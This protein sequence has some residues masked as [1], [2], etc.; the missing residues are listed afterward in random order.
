MVAE[1]D[2]PTYKGWAVTCAPPAVNQSEPPSACAPVATAP[3]TAVPP[4]V[5]SN[6]VQEGGFSSVDLSNPL[7]KQAAPRQPVVATISIADPGKIAFDEAATNVSSV[8]STITFSFKVT[9]PALVRYQLLQ[10]SRRPSNAARGF[11]SV[12]ALAGAAV[13]TGA[14][15]WWLP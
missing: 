5:E 4:A 12:G 2:L 11:G 3:C 8:G 15:G 7:P 10:V 9:K 1:D 6:N 14:A 13:R